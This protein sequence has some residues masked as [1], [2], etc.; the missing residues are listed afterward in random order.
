MEFLTISSLQGKMLPWVRPSILTC[1][2]TNGIP[3][4]ILHLRTIKS[5]HL[6][7]QQRTTPMT[8]SKRPLPTAIA[9]LLMEEEIRVFSSS[10]IAE[11]KKPVFS[12][13]VKFK[14]TSST[15]VPHM[16]LSKI[17]R[18]LPLSI[19]LTYRVGD[20]TPSDMAEIITCQ[21]SENGGK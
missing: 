2:S 18:L 15:S 20:V 5:K 11:A 4:A 9:C 8:I 12:Q 14:K 21:A 6:G 19:F 3:M 16:R 17:L 7:S 13:T 10:A 1:W